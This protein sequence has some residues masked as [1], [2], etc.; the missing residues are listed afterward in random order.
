MAEMFWNVI[1]WTFRKERT[2]KN[3]IAP[4]PFGIA[5]ANSAAF[6]L[7]LL[8]IA[9]LTPDFTVLPLHCDSKFGKRRRQG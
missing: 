8:T 5:P 7:S 6:L 3:S 2:L 1:K 4:I 9:D